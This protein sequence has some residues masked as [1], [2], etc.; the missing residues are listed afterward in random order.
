MKNINKSY[1][2][3]GATGFLGSNLIRGL[4]AHNH[5]VYCLRRQ[6][7][8]NMRL[9]D[10]TE[11]IIWIDLESL[12]PMHFFTMNVIDGIIHCATDYGRKI[13]DPLQTIEAN[14][15]LPL[16]LLHAAASN[17]ISLFLNTDTML[18]KLINNYSLSKSQFTDWLNSYSD[19]IC[20]INVVLEHFYG[21]GDDDTKFTTFVIKSLISQKDILPLTIG[22][23]KRDFIY[24]DDV[25]AAIIILLNNSHFLKNGYYRYEIGTGKSVSIREFVDLV[26][27]L[28]LN[29]NTVLAYGALP[30]RKGE[31]MQ[32]K[33]DNS[34]IMKLGWR[35]TVSLEEGLSRTIKF[36]RSKDVK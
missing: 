15:I 35:P 22:N 13:V 32:T 34:N 21:G 30:Y 27:S 17:G 33:V 29:N 24:I 12:N 23:Q 10:I 3:T 7:S 16:K 19:R 11:K 4:L 1:F 2:I 9:K 14:L 26:K 28:T 6:S 36:E 20:G 8:N 5:T 31:I 18:D 25:V